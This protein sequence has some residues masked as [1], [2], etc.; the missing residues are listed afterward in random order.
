MALRA[1][2][3]V[4]VETVEGIRSALKRA[5]AGSAEFMDAALVFGSGPRTCGL[6]VVGE[7][8][9]RDETRE[10]APFV[11][12]AGRFFISVM[13]GAL[14]VK[15]CEVYI[16]NVVKVWPIIQTKRLKTRPPSR[17]ETAFFRPYLLREAVA[18]APKVII[19][20][21]KTA[22]T[23]LAPDE[24]FTPGQWVEG[25]DGVMIM[26][27]YHPAYI[28]RRQRQLG[29]NTEA[30]RQALRRVKGRLT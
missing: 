15:R 1:V 25:P 10:G 20:V 14:G 19:A 30:L 23:A 4:R 24:V 18:V 22:F 27:V 13:E 11:G 3:K 12:K 26:P 8:P 2:N 7:A 21:G 17:E 5:C 6:M 28:L 29:E 9:G 16:T